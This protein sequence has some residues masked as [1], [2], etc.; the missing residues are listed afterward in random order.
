MCECNLCGCGGSTDDLDITDQY[1]GEGC[2]RLRAAMDMKR[3]TTSG[4]Q[5]HFNTVSHTAD[6]VMCSYPKSRLYSSG[7]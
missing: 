3:S 2:P 5:V 7:L 4:E 1:S 6:R